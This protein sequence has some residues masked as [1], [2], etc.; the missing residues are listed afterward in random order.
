MHVSVKKGM[1]TCNVKH[2]EW[3]GMIKTCIVGVGEK[4]TM[5]VYVYRGFVKQIQTNLEFK[6]A[7]TIFSLEK[8]TRTVGF[9]TPMNMVYRTIVPTFMI[10][11]QHQQNDWCNHWSDVFH[12]ASDLD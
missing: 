6:S 3:S 7:A 5:Y 12:F 9:L 8:W 1:Q 2:F 4:D 10:L 11:M